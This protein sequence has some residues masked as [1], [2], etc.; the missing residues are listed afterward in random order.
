[1]LGH[2]VNDAA[3]LL[4]GTGMR[5][6]RPYEVIPECALK[7][8][9]N[10]LRGMVRQKYRWSVVTDSLDSPDRTAAG[11]CAEGHD[12]EEIANQYG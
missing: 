2:L 7:E 10:A 6:N 1:M 5:S 11:A 12:L 9:A 3:A 8:N 4:L